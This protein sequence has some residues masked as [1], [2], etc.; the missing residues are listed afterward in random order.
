MI[1]VTT[2]RRVEF[3]SIE[4]YV[5]YEVTG[6]RSLDMPYNTYVDYMHGLEINQLH[7]VVVTETVYNRGGLQ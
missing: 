1:I 6:C 5:H 3:D 7:N 2:V 4:E